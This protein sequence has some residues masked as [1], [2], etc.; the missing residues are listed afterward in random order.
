MAN[1][2][3]SKKEE[4]ISAIR[5]DGSP[6]HI[7]YLKALPVSGMKPDPADPV[8]QFPKSLWCFEP[9]RRSSAAS[10]SW[11]NAVRV[12]H[13]ASGRY[14][15]VD[16]RAALRDTARE[17][18]FSAILVD[19]AL[20]APVGMDASPPSE[21][22][23]DP[24]FIEVNADQLLFRVTSTD[25]TAS[26]TIP[27]LDI[28]VRLEFHGQDSFGQPLVLH[29]HNTE[30]RKPVRHGNSTQSSVVARSF[31][32]AFSTVP[33]AEDVLKIMKSIYFHYFE[34]LVFF[35]HPPPPQKK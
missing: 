14:L 33:A 28:S 10:V 18:W 5:I 21:Q 6:L 15:A 7:P 2:D 19:D 20:V 1:P 31:Q 27:D 16:T 30:E 12:R 23:L 35:S 13:V 26:Q 17:T 4:Q 25:A 11:G 8:H 34:T 3:K 24:N 9:P 22:S 29:L 32:L